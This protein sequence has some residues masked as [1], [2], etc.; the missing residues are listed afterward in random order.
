[1]D[2]DKLKHDFIN[3]TIRIE[4]LQKLI[5]ESLNENKSINEQYKIDLAKFYTEQINYLKQIKT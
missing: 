5:N 1:M 4:I 2:Q 3:N